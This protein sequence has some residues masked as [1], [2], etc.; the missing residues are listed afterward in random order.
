VRRLSRK[1]GE[2]RV[3]KAGW[4]QLRWSRAVPAPGN[5]QTVGIDRGGEWLSVDFHPTTA[6]PRLDRGRPRSA[7]RATP[8]RAERAPPLPDPRGS[9]EHDGHRGRADHAV[10]LACGLRV[11]NGRYG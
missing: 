5:G 1:T 10:G 6:A 4:V 2:F 7:L 11:C 8:D 3:P 9:E